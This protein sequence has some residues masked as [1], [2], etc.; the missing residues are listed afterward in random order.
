MAPYGRRLTLVLVAV[1]IATGLSGA[2]LAY[3]IGHRSVAGN[4]TVAGG[5][6]HP[7]AE[8]TPPPSAGGPSHSS[9]AAAPESAV[10]PV[11]VNL[12]PSAENAPQ[13]RDVADL[14]ARY[15]GAINRNDY[16]AWLATVTTEQA[17][18]DRDTWTL[19]YSTTHDSDVYVSDITP[20]DPLTVRMQFVSRQSLEFAPAALPAECVRW[21]V[22]YRILDEG[23]GLRVGTS[24]KEPALAPC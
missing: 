15:F 16:D 24:A 17:R 12:S 13:A 7:G 11:S 5:S 6:E 4:A 20:G 21:D 18:R 10:G 1:L 8:A 2:A 19:D 14:I 23:V 3:L 22:T 9:A